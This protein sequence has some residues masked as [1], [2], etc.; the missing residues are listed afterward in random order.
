MKTMKSLPNLKSSIIRVAR[1][2]AIEVAALAAFASQALAQQIQNGGGGDAPF[3]QG[4]TTGLS[5]VHFGAAAIAIVAF[6]VGCVLLFNRNVFG[7]AAA[8]FFAIIGG[9]LLANA[10]SIMTTLTGLN[11]A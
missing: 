11:F 2:S 6:L 8:F 7:A 9:A 1:A 3:V 10:N 5:W 4:V